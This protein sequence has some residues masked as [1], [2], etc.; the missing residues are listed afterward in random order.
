[1]FIVLPRLLSWRQRYRLGCVRKRAGSAAPI[2]R[3]AGLNLG[4]FLNGLDLCCWQ[5]CGESAWQA[6]VAF[7]WRVWSRRR[8]SAR[9]FD[10]GAIHW[11]D[12]IEFWFRL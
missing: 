9:A 2:E 5:L 4:L 10:E 11:I 6:A 12:V 1:M 3:G 7:F 8:E